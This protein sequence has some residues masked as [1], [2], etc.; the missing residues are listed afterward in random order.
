[1]K[2]SFCTPASMVLG[3][4]HST[5]LAAMEFTDRIF[6]H[7]DDKKTPLAIFIDLSK[8]FDTIDH[9]IMLDKLKHYGIKGTALKWFTSYLSFRTQ[10][11]QYKEKCSS[12]SL[13]TTGV[14][15]GSILGPLL[16]IIYI[17]DLRYVSDKFKCIIYADDTTLDEPI[18]S[19]KNQTGTSLK[20]IENAINSE[21]EKVVEWLAL[22][23]L[24]LNAK[25]TKMMLFHYKQRNVKNAIPKLKI[26]GITIERVK[27][28]NFLGLT[29]D[30]NMTWK[31]HAQKIANKISQVIGTLKRLKHF[32]PPNILKTLYCSLI[33]PHLHYGIILWGRNTK[34]INKLQK[35][36]VRQ[37]VNAKYN[38]H[39]EPIMK[40]LKLRKVNDLYNLA[41][42][43]LYHK[44]KNIDLPPY[45]ATIFENQTPNHDYNTRH[46]N[47]TH[48]KPNTISA[49]HSPRYCIP[50]LVESLPESIISTVKEVS[51]KGFSSANKKHFLSN[52]QNTCLV[53]N[54]YI[55][56]E[57]SH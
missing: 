19:F 17:N 54:C 26:N 52:Y 23:K 1:M 16:F 51:L 32:L 5:E 20:E 56:N 49:S 27:E 36:A 12:K 55:C 15:Q 37:I 9:S 18:C 29:I 40:K 7:L 57:Y 8:A 10:Y 4:K 22:N 33:L 11:V 50:R 47:N 31:A 39:T 24:S 46:R 35:W 3:K 13:I 42:L 2:I 25:K 6:K 21:L 30:E 41:A 38:S 43:K 14:P 34:R 45:F 44:Y 48:Q 53:Y 28:F